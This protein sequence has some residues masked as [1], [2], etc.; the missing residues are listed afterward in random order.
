MPSCN[1]EKPHRKDRT[2]VP[3]WFAHTTQKYMFPT[4]CHLCT[5]KMTQMNSFPADLLVLEG[6]MLL[7]QKLHTSSTSWSHCQSDLQTTSNVTVIPP[8]TKGHDLRAMRVDTCHDSWKEP[9]RRKRDGSPVAEISL[10]SAKSHEILP[11]FRV[12]FLLFLSSCDFPNFRKLRSWL[13]SLSP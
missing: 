7:Q 13:M 2:R 6:R 12:H 3:G 11:C 8:P 4:G 1:E 10:P 9:W 5:A